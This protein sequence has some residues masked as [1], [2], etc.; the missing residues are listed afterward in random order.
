VSRSTIAESKA[1]LVTGGA[2]YIGSHTC[3]ALSLAG[4]VPVTYD[5]LVHGHRWAIQWGPFVHGDLADGELLAGTM[6][7]YSVAAVIHFAGYAYVGESMTQPGK[8]FR[9]NMSNTLTLLEA[10]VS[11][12]VPHIVFSS[13]CA[14]YG[15]PVDL[16]IRE[17]HPQQP[18]NPYGESK[19]VVE[20]M[21]QWWEAAHQIRWSALRYFNAAG[22]DL[23]GEVGEDHDP[24][25]HLVPLAIEAALRTRGPLEIYGSD[26]PTPDGTAVRDYVHV[27]D[28]AAA[29]VRALQYL[30]DGG[31]S[32]VLNLGT[33]T[34]HSVRDVIAMV[35]HVSGRTVP[36]RTAPR[37]PGDPAQLVACAARARDVLGWVP[38]HSS[39]RAIVESAWQWHT[40]G[41]KTMAKHRNGPSDAAAAPFLPVQAESA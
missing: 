40:E 26:Y 16:P 34:G 5:N 3:K 25:T 13:T 27:S 35:E 17:Q 1:V 20:R 10:M 36:V 11:A 23:D 31:S 21:L 2:G 32:I 30:R 4:Y 14:I 15:L 19:L 8:Y 41:Q 37:R 33:G 29:H 39:L 28:L 22:A 24:E 12:G 7:R 6:R 18:I 9:N 38:R